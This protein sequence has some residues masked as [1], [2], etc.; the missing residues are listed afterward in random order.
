MTLLI[1]ALTIGLIL[2]LLALGV[3]ISFRVFEFPTSPPTIDHPRRG[4]RG[5][6]A[7]A[8]RASGGRDAGG[9]AAPAASPAR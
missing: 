3:F 1:G 2:S 7:G 6:A 5:G 4:R 9:C 8:S